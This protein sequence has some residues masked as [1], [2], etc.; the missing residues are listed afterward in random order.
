[1]NHIL[2]YSCKLLLSGILCLA[3]IPAYCAG[4]VRIMP[5]GDS[6]TR[7]S[8]LVYT[9]LPDKQGG[10]WRKLLQDKLRKEGIAYEFVGELDYHSYGDKGVIAP[11]FSPGHHGLA[12]F[13]CRQILTGGIVPTPQDVLRLKNVPQI[14]VP[15]IVEAI[16][17]NHPDI[18]LLMA[19]SNGLNST[20]RD[21]LM[22]TILDHFDGELF[23]AT[24]PPQKA[25]RPGWKSVAAFNKSLPT[26]IEK[27]RDGHP[28]LFPVD[29]YSALNDGDI[30]PDGVHPNQQGNIKIADTWYQSLMENSGV[31]KRYQQQAVPVAAQTAGIGDAEWAV[32]KK[33][34][35]E[36]PRSVIVNND[37]CDLTWLWRKE[38]RPVTQEKFDAKRMNVLLGKE[39]DT[40]TYTPFCVGMRVITRS[41]VADIFDSGANGLSKDTYNPTREL[42]DRGTDA[43]ELAVNF[44]RAHNLEIFA[45]MRVNDIHDSWGDGKLTPFKEE[46]PE[47]IVGARD[48]R[49]P[50]GAW[51]AFDFAMKPVRDRFVGICREFMDNY[52]VDGLELDFNRWPILFKSVAWKGSATPEDTAM[53]TSMMREIRNAGEQIGRRHGKPRLIAVNIPDSPAVCNAFGMDVE[54]W[55]GEDLV[56]LL[57]IGSDACNYLPKSKAIAEMK[58]FGKPVYMTCSVPNMGR[59]VRNDP[60]EP[61]D[62]NSVASQVGLAA[63]ALSGNPDG[64]NYFNT[65]CIPGTFDR[66]R[67]KLCDLALFDKIYHVTPSGV[68][69]NFPDRD[70]FRKD[71]ALYPKSPKP[72]SPGEKRRFL[73]DIGD[74]FSRPEVAAAKPEIEL[75]LEAAAAPDCQLEIRI[76]G[77]PTAP[78]RTGEN[79]IRTVSIPPALLKPG[80]NVVEIANITGR[81]VD[82]P[83][84]ILSG[85]HHPEW[86]KPAPWTYLS[87][88]PGSVKNEKGSCRITDHSDVEKAGLVFLLPKRKEVKIEFELETLDGE[89]ICR[90]ANG[91]FVETVTFGNGKV[92]CEFA[93]KAVQFHTGDGF[94][95]YSI[96]MSA[97]EIAVEAD[98]KPLLNAPLT[99][100]VDD[101]AAKRDLGSSAAMD[102]IDSSVAIGSLS[103]PGTGS[104]RWR[105]MT[106]DLDSSAILCDLALVVK[107][108]A[109]RNE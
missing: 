80:T 98:G 73:L 100:R 20:D 24:I 95:K 9:G 75:F 62:R 2:F 16:K 58:R 18:I 55:C 102:G 35:K 59:C 10:G 26:A 4:P 82:Y 87:N 7:G 99:V 72:L 44:C 101:P 109:N 8:Y 23:I 19:G 27:M 66:I 49:P 63:A 51:T 106:L 38:D 103:G 42:H 86:E 61:F 77:K 36:R 64:L 14:E 88:L 78:L 25:P 65:Y 96:A 12:G 53:L 90:L 48:R 71:P 3:A 67:R 50:F 93:G 68:L 54:T 47:F 57:I 22:K 91:S 70:K 21:T 52:D 104:A 74:D 28:R 97:G 83:Y 85:K 40:F 107:F 81:R 76:N 33:K 84:A 11:G 30:L 6:I 5:V 32:L 31:I 92:G 43:L 108:P 89:V 46:H 45:S 39:I 69:M 56:D 34:A 41:K 94:R 17:R 13:S 1:M 37:G 15:G 79:S 105:N 60:K 29:M